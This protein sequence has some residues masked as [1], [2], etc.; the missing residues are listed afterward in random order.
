MEPNLVNRCGI[1]Q[2][3]F[4]VYDHIQSPHL[5]VNNIFSTITCDSTKAEP[6]IVVSGF[7]ILLARYLEGLGSCIEYTYVAIHEFL[8]HVIT[9]NSIHRALDSMNMI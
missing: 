8:T 2:I 1:T 7:Q 4:D 5:Y 6:D 3:K 9:F